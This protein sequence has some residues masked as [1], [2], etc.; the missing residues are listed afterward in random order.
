MNS[1]IKLLFAIL[2]FASFGSCSKEDNL[3]KSADDIITQA[4]KTVVTGTWIVS[5]YN[6]KGTNQTGNFANY[7]F[8]FLSNNTVKATNG[9][10]TINGTWKTGTDDSNAKFNLSFS[11]ANGPFEEISEDWRIV[12]ITASKIDL[13]HI[14]GGNGGQSLI[15]FIKI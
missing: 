7:K 6:E 11:A 1:L 13:H 9:T 3:S 10:N 8:T 4:S 12:E 15:T 5:N 14:S 2:F